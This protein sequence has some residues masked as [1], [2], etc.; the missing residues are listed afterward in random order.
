M[1][2]ALGVDELGS[3]FEPGRFTRSAYKSSFN[4]A[5]WAWG[6]GLRAYF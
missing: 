3:R 6:V 4:L 5:S 2:S 1:L